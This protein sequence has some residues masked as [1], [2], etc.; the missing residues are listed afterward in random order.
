MPDI[1]LVASSRTA[2]PRLIFFLACLYRF[3]ALDLVMDTSHRSDILE[4]FALL[5]GSEVARQRAFVGIWMCGD[6]ISRLVAF[7]RDLLRLA[8]LMSSSESSAELVELI[9]LA[10]YSQ[11]VAA[12]RG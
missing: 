8:S 7:S 11:C 3:S 9:A 2:S 10:R 6:A 5:G 4:E 12:S 1:A